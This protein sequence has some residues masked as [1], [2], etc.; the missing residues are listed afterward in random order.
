LEEAKKVVG[1]GMG[2]AAR[3]PFAELASLRKKAGPGPE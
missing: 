1:Q 3:N 2:E